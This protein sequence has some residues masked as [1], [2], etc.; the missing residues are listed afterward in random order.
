MNQDQTRTAGPCC[1]RVVSSVLE[2][3]RRLLRSLLPRCSRSVAL[4]V[5]EEPGKH[6]KEGLLQVGC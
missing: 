2:R 4:M 5:A 6:Q 3:N 1:E